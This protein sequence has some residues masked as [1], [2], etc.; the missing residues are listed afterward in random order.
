MPPPAATRPGASSDR[1]ST[2]RSDVCVDEHQAGA[3]D[4]YDSESTVAARNTND[5]TRNRS[6]IARLA[7]LDLG[8]VRPKNGAGRLISKRPCTV[9]RAYTQAMGTGQD[10]DTFIDMA[11]R[12]RRRDAERRRQATAERGSAAQERVDSEQTRKLAAMVRRHSADRR[13]RL[14]NPQGSGL[15][16][17]VHAV[18][19]PTPDA[20]RDAHERRQMADARD[21]ATDERERR[22]DKRD[23]VADE[24]DHLADLQEAQLDERERGL[25]TT[26][27]A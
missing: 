5:P 17:Q 10:G 3:A 1:W 7:W 24:R 9:P 14:A 23:A 2:P 12:R 8:K 6:R 16:G 15:G 22:A 21:A 20:D 13:L 11:L 18:S 27:G 25:D 19:C 26:A 4:M